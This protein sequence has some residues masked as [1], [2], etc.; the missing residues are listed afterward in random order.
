MKAPDWSF[1]R[2]GWSF[3]SKGLERFQ[4]EDGVLFYEWVDGEFAKKVPIKEQ[5]I[6]ILHNAIDYP[7]KYRLRKDIKIICLRELIT[8]SCFLESID[9]CLCLFTLST[10]TADFLKEHGINAVPLLH[11]AKKIFD[12]K[13]F[14]GQIVIVGQWMRDFDTMSLLE[15]NYEKIVLK[16]PT[17]R[18]LIE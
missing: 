12:W 14:Q 18:R 9:K 1:H 3:V 15:S 6:G 5:W 11:P 4:N 16:V 13:G 2:I 8:N 17:I 10:R 7:E